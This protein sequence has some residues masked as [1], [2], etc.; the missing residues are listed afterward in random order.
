MEY[1]SIFDRVVYESLEKDMRFIETKADFVEFIKN[2][3]ANGSYGKDV[4]DILY[5]FVQEKYPQW[6]NLTKMLFT[7]S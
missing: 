7:L 5:I 4:A 6:L 1:K 2:E 3:I